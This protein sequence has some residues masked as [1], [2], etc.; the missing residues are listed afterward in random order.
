VVHFISAD[1]EST[2]LTIRLSGPFA[3]RTLFLIDEAATSKIS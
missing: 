3:Q 2:F 1:S